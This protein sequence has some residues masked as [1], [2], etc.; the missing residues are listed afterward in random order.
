MVYFM[1]YFGVGKSM[2]LKLIMGIECINGGSI[3]FNGYD[4]ICFVL[5]ELL[6]LCC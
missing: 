3:E 2:L 4:I 6:F 1:G 5:Y